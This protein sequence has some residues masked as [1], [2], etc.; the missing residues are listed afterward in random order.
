MKILKE[1][2]NYFLESRGLSFSVL[3]PS[4]KMVIEIAQRLGCW[5]A[6]GAALAIYSEDFNGIRD[7]DLFFQL[8]EEVEIAKK[9]LKAA[10]F[11]ESTLSN[12]SFT[13]T[14]SDVV[15]QLIHKNLFK[16][17]NEIFNGFDFT[18]CCFAISD[19]NIYYTSKAKN[20]LEAKQFDFIFTDCVGNCIKRIA[21]YGAKGYTPS[22]KFIVD[23][24]KRVKEIPIQRI[25]YIGTGQS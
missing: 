8:P 10:G 12:W 20:S 5:I 21:K 15:I 11:V 3:P 23:F 9:F 6:G 13:F 4:V 22:N 18:I 24:S 14:K 2:L 25:E 19:G 1:N 7:Y 17:V 16:S